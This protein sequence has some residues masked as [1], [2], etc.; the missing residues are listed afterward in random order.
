MAAGGPGVPGLTNIFE[1][2]LKTDL[3]GAS[4]ELTLLPHKGRRVEI[5]GQV[6]VVPPAGLTRNVG[7]NLID[8]AGGDSGGAPAA[9]TLYYVY[10]SNRMASFRPESIALSAT[11]PSLVDGV[12]YLAAVGNGSNWRFVGWVR[13]NATPQFES[14]VLNRLVV[15]YYNR[16]ALNLYVNPGYAD[17]NAQ[18]SYSTSSAT[19]VTLASIIG[20]GVSQVTF[21]S[22]GEDAVEYYA[23]YLPGTGGTELALAGIGEDNQQNPAVSALQQFIGVSAA[24]TI[25]IGKST[26]FAEGFHTLDMLFASDGQTIIFYADQGRLAGESTDSPGTMLSGI[27]YG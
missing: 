10:V 26:D 12:K 3:N 19:Y 5:R 7:D 17:N 14:T 8:A 21:I 9:S 11:A 18:T 22:N 2:R 24:N 4:S 6:I 15:N 20:S 23:T 13:P 1:A 16:L 25:S 27:V